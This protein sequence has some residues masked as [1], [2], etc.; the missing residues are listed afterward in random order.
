[1]L[2][3]DVGERMDKRVEGWG[4]LVRRMWDMGIS[5]VREMGKRCLGSE[6]VV[7]DLGRKRGKVFW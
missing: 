5:F 2:V 7:N 1:M 4:D 6:R 3:L